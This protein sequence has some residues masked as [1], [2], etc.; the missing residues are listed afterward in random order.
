MGIERRQEASLADRARTALG[1]KPSRIQVAAL[2]WRIGAQGVEIML[3]TSRATGRW[4]L[5]KGW[6]ERGERLC[7]AAAREAGEE[8]GI[9][10]AVA[11]PE[12]GMYRYVKRRTAGATTPCQVHVFAMEI[13]R[14]R[15]KWPERKQRVRAWFTVEDAALSVREP[16]L[17][18]LIRG[19]GGRPRTFAT[20]LVRWPE[21]QTE[22]AAN[23]TSH[24]ESQVQ[25]V[26][27]DSHPV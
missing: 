23:L 3:V 10:G 17:E 24:G 5:P 4:V 21:R 25:A 1:G 7:D 22:L 14:V 6:P 13:D 27:S 16:E 2:P 15:E 18:T 19:F 9:S 26:V 12:I 11:M 20:P 8:A